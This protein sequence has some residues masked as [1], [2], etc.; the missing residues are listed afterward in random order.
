MYCFSGIGRTSAEF[1]LL[2][3]KYVHL[4]NFLYVVVSGFAPQSACSGF[5]PESLLKLRVTCRELRGP[6][7]M[8]TCKE[9]GL[10]VV[11]SYFYHCILFLL[12]FLRLSIVAYTKV[13]FQPLI[14]NRGSVEIYE[15]A[16]FKSWKFTQLRYDFQMIFQLIVP[17]HAKI[18]V[19]DIVN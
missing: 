3:V 12:R 10:S 16:H 18:S 2:M 17:F 6:H 13:V 9:N 11:L 19:V 1:L 15:L 14:S 8:A 4:K 5:N 7:V